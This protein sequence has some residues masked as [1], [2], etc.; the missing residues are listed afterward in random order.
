MR[1]AKIVCTLGPASADRDTIQGLADA[2]MAVARLNTSHG[3][4]AERRTRIDHV[5]AVDAESTEPVAVL[6]DLAGPEIRTGAHDRP[7]T[8]SADDT[9]ALS[10]TDQT[11]EE[12]IEIS[13]SLA[14]IDA[15]QRIL[16]DDGRVELIATDTAGDTITATVNTG[17]TLQSNRSVIVPGVDLALPFVSEADHAELALAASKSVD[18]VAASFVSD[19]TDLFQ[20]SDIL[21]DEGCADIAL[22]AKI[23]RA[24]ALE[25]LTEIID[26][27]DAV[28]IARGDLGV[29]CPLEDV[30]LIQKRVITQC[31]AHGVPVI[32]A[33]D[34][35]DSMIDATR[36]TRAEASDVANAVLDGT[37]AL[38]L[39]GETAI[40][41][42]PL[43]AVETM[44]RI[45]RRVESS[46]EYANTREQRIPAADQT[47]TTDALTRSARYLARD[48]GASAIV[49]ASESGYTARKA[50]KFRPG[51]PIVATTPIDHV[52]RRL[53]LSWGVHPRRV[54]PA[55]DVSDVLANAIEAA[56]DTPVAESGD[57]IVILSGM[58]TDLQGTDATN[59]LKVHVVAETL[60]TGRAVVPG[61]A[62]GP[63]Q[64]YEQTSPASIPENAVLYLAG[65][66]DTEFQ[67]DLGS[68]SAILAAEP[69]L[70]GYP[71]IIARELDIP[72]IS[73]CIIPES[74]RDE[75]ILTVDGERG[76][77]YR[78][79]V[80]AES[81]YHVTDT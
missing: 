44:D 39:S 24:A 54:P 17:G 70:T 2:G 81:Q 51:V 78:G 48:V 12:H 41:G 5:R 52:R 30:P 8:L 69:G 28:M 15:G 75:T 7:I 79:D 13:H 21:Q 49:V 10:P 60:S 35:L 36:P 47:I 9:V 34:M 19:A 43:S 72:M 40:G 61:L 68:V 37:D 62:A 74:V 25:N 50:A 58:M 38:M 46:G 1:H 56:L 57:T 67:D 63:F 22:I 77:V 20:I 73:G 14:G 3:S 55:G 80:T 66:S 71:A 4:T 59:T 23:E 64:R 16:L 6:L 76:V 27:A 32:T 18:F 53:T 33:T 11:T 31:Q 29:E 45:I 42:D 65:D 26:A